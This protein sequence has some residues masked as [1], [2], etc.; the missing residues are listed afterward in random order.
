VYKPYEALGFAQLFATV[1]NPHFV[2]VYKPY[3]ALGFA[4]LFATVINRSGWLC[5]PERLITSAWQNQPEQLI[6]C[7]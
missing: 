2:W 4:Q 6:V 1:N 3:E 7:I 5:Q